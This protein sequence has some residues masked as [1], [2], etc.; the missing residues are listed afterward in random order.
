MVLEGE[1]H[2]PLFQLVEK[3]GK[4]VGRSLITKRVGWALIEIF[5]V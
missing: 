2:A 5:Q 3:V 4:D 1:F